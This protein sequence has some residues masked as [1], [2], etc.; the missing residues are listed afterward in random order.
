LSV[1]WYESAR[2]ERCVCPQLAI[3]VS[4][5]LENQPDGSAAIAGKVP[6]DRLDSALGACQ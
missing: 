4:Y 6:V 5:N 3:S 2:D 1:A